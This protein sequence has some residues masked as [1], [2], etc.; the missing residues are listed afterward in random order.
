MNKTNTAAT[1]KR[2][3]TFARLAGKAIAKIAKID[4]AAGAAMSKAAQVIA[5]NMRNGT[6]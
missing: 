1:E 3:A 4:P 5:D 2:I 6:V